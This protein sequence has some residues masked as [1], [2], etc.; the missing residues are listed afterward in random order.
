MLCQSW[1]KG[2]D[3]AAQGARAF[4]MNDADG[5]DTLDPALRKPRGQ[6]IREIAGTE[7]VEVKIAGNLN[8]DGI[9]V[10]HAI[11]AGM[12]LAGSTPV[13]RWSRPWDFTVKRSWS[14][15]RS[16]STVA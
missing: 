11:R 7:G 1:Q 3:S 6:K 12:A 16:F 9:R 15:P 10:H 2:M 13:S 8:P 14:K 4:A 5:K